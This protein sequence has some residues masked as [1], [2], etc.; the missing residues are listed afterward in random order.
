MPDDESA[1]SSPSC[2]PF[3]SS[4][5]G[6]P[7]VFQFRIELREVKPIV[8]RR[9][10]V[11]NDMTLADLHALVRYAMGWDDLHLQW[12]RIHGRGYR[13]DSHLLRTTRL[14]ALRLKPGERFFYGYNPFDGWTHDVRLESVLSAERGRLYPICIAGRHACPP[15]WCSGPQ[16]YESA[17][18][19]AMGL[20]YI[21]DLDQLVGFASHLLHCPEA[22]RPIFGSDEERYNLRKL[23]DR[24]G[25]R[26]R[27]WAPF[28]RAAANAV[29]RETFSG[30]GGSAAP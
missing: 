20:A 8:W 10:H 28:D 4:A 14:D 27:L 23:L 25:R 22:L 13:S 5:S 19:D 15:E 11:L 2:G 24:M 9:V 1:V 18:L 17:R 26:E 3:A 29:L 7:L 30:E 16:E 6:E 12:F 21:E